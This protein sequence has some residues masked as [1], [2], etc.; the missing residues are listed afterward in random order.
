[1]VN[2]ATAFCTLGLWHDVITTGGMGG[3][4]EGNDKKYDQTLVVINTSS[5]RYDA[6]PDG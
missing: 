5:A 6:E 1:M 3:T 4:F 2:G